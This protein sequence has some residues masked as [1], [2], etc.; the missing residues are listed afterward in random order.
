[1]NKDSKILIV[2]HNDIIEQLLTK[3][4]RSAGYTNVTSS[5]E[6]ALNTT[7]QPSVYEFFQN[8]RPEYIFLGSTRSGGIQ[9]NIDNPAEFLYHNL[10]SQNNIIYSAW[11][12]GAKKLFYIGASCVYPK[13]C[14]QPMKEEHLLTGSLEETSEAYSLAKIAGI[15]LC[16]A[17]RKQYGF[18]A[19]A[20]I[21]ATIYGQQDDI[22]VEKAHVMGALIGK[23]TQAIKEN[24]KEVVVWGTG[25][26]RRE[27]LYI[28]D[29]IDACLFLLEHYEE[30][31]VINIGAGKDVS[32]KELAEL[33]AKLTNFS[34]KI[35][36]DS[37]KPNGAPQKLL[38]SGRIN[39]LGWQPKV[40]LDEG[41]KRI[42]KK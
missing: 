34:G 30:G 5:S 11:K 40:S 23:F 41:I 32:I 22:D 24:K 6:I 28:D 33:I 35:I 31:Q 7:V 14:P 36:Y 1:M 2:G 38:D 3:H 26:P 29:F 13:D 27:F 9:A 21:P 39:K 42:V 25:K 37:S 16:Q 8:N 17:Y 4:L 10:E 15:K 18:N 20:V 12:F 19:I